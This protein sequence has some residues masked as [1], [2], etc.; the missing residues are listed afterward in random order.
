MNEMAT[1]GKI[2]RAN[3]ENYEIQT[4]VND[5][6]EEEQLQ[7]QSIITKTRIENEHKFLEV[8]QVVKSLN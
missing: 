2:K 8:R 4:Q 7:N 6:P 5:K 3:C 1:N